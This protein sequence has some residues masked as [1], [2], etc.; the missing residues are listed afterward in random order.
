MS[1]LARTSSIHDVLTS[2]YRR[3][4]IFPLYRNFEL[5]QKVHEDVCRIVKNG[6]RSVLRALLECKYIFDRSESRFRMSTIY[7]TDYCVW[8]QTLQ[9]E[10][11][12]THLAE[13]V[14]QTVVSKQ[15]VD[16]SLDEYE[17]IAQEDLAQNQEMLDEQD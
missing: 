10:A 5:V 4:L 9:D 3:A 1:W 14:R 8:V 2:S 7:L 12:W 17:S 16:L 11:F 13:T 15:D 6:P